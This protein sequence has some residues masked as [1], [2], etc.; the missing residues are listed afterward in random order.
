[1][2]V[3]IEVRP[4]RLDEIEAV[5]PLYQWLFAPPGSEPGSWDERRAAVALR[6][7]I[8][9][10]DAAVLVADEDGRLVAFLTA[11][12]DI[13]SVRFGYRAWIEDFAVDPERRSAGIGKRM[14]DAAR[15]WARERGATHLELDSSETRHDA[16]RFYE[17]EAP[18][19]RSLCFGWEL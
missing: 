16:H 4:A 19:W 6:Q 11:Y 13:H 18:S 2:G 12:Q 8:E 14:L 9:S 15:G 5:I 17:R 7:A 3:A 10:H 1:V